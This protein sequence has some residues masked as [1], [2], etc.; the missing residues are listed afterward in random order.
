MSLALA[1]DSEAF[2]SPQ[3]EVESRPEPFRDLS[4]KMILK[5]GTEQAMELINIRHPINQTESEGEH[6]S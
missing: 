5:T 4:L 1:L 6:L 2:F 3:Q